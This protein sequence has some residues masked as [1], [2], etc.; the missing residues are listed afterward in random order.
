MTLAQAAA[1]VTAEARVLPPPLLTAVVIN[2]GGGG[3][4]PTVPMAALLMAV[5]ID[6]SGSNGVVATA[7]NDNN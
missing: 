5:A 2:G 3:M 7:V 4:E 1:I 6:G